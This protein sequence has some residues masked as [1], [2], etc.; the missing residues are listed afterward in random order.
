MAMNESA[1]QK[2]IPITRIELISGLACCEDE[3]LH[4]LSQW[5][6]EGW[7]V[8]EVRRMCVVLEHAPPAQ[9][10]FAVDYQH[11][12]DAEYFELCRMAEWTHVVSLSHSIHLFN[13]PIGTRSL[14]SAHDTTMVVR[15]Q[16]RLT[17][18]VLVCGV[19]LVIMMWLAT[20]LVW[21]WLATLDSGLLRWVFV[22]SG[23]VSMYALMVMVWYTALPW[24]VYQMRRYGVNV[25]WSR[26]RAGCVLMG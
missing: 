19:A 12:P 26:H 16:Q 10:V 11:H 9:V 4:R 1:W 2:L 21:P 5:A 24:V 23:F 20:T 17:R 13:A 25:R 15:A 8:V 14:F 22:G 3:D 7:Q 6:A 18:A